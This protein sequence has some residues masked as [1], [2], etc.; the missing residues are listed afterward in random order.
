MSKVKNQQ[1]ALDIALEVCG[2][3]ED[4]Y[5]LCE[6]NGW[7]MTD[8]LSVG[9]DITEIEPTSTDGRDVVLMY[10][11]SPIAPATAIG[12]D[13][14]TIGGIGYMGISIDFKVS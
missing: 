4:A 14:P 12:A 13:T 10:S 9:E 2:S 5:A 1:T 6:A 11:G 7:G 3:I 8:T